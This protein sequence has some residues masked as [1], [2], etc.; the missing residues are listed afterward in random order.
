MGKIKNI[1]FLLL[2]IVMLA[3]LV[4]PFFLQLKISIIKIES[5]ERLEKKNLLSIHILKKNIHW[6]RLNKELIIDNRLFD[7]KHHSQIG[8]ELVVTGIFDDN[9]T[10]VEKQINDFW[11][12]QKT[13]QGIFLLKFLQELGNSCFQKNIFQI[14]V[15]ES[16]CKVYAGIIFF[17][18]KDVFIKI[19]S[20]P[21]QV[22]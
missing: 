14:E 3:P 13:R 12:Q 8:A 2:F 5:R 16:D 7:V 15:P 18:Q 10:K 19:P 20:P 22:S 9:E 21:P 1:P 17:C 11:E 6:V 4:T